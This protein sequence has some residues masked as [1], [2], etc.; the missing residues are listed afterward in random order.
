MSTTNDRLPEVLLFSRDDYCPQD[1]GGPWRERARITRAATVEELEGLLDEDRTWDLALVD[2]MPFRDPAALPPAPTR[3]AATTGVG[4][5]LLLREHRPGLTTVALLHSEDM[6]AAE[7]VHAALCSW[8]GV[9][10]VGLARALDAPEQ[11]LAGDAASVAGGL[12]DRMREL[13]TALR[14]LFDVL[15]ER[16]ARTSLRSLLLW[17]ARRGDR[18][19]YVAAPSALEWLRAFEEARGVGSAAAARLDVGTSVLADRRE[20]ILPLLRRIEA[21]TRGRHAGEVEGLLDF[22]SRRGAFLRHED[23]GRAWEQAK[24]EHGKDL[25]GETAS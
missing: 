20:R 10:V 4:V 15:E 13:G 1:D 24:R 11:L 25:S 9:P 21:A 6:S 5:I 14:E 19:E 2:P 12:N 17:L 22:L 16:V 7:E 3:P 8:L 18:R 23:V